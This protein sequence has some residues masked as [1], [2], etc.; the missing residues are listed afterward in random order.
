MIYCLEILTAHPCYK[1][2]SASSSLFFYTSE[3]EAN[4]KRREEKSIYY[5]SFMEQLKKEDDEDDIDVDDINE[6]DASRFI[7]TNSYMDMEPFSSTLYEVSIDGNQVTYKIIPPPTD[8][9]L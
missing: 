9:L 4:E 5:E 1:R 3:K 2:P 7:Y 6:E 8:L